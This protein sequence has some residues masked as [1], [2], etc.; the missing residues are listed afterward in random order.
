[1]C[2]EPTGNLDTRT[3]KDVIRLFRKLNQENGITVILVTHDQAVAR[4]ARRIIVLAMIADCPAAGSAY[5][6]PRC[7]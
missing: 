6:L 4:S 5:S 3:S 2:D 1:M 7:P